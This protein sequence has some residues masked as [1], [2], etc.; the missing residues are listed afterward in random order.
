MLDVVHCLGELERRGVVRA[1]TPALSH[2]DAQPFLDAGFVLHENLHLLSRQLDDEPQTG[3]LTLR[4][5]RP[6]HRRAVLAVDA[7]AFEPFWQF[8][9]FSLRE[10]R[11]ATPH[12]RFRVAVLDSS[13]VGYAVT[14]R[15]GA[16]GYLQRLAVSPEAA[17]QGIGTAL[18]QDGF[19]WLRR[20]DAHSVMVNTQ[21]HN[22]RA[23][24]LYEHLG[25]VRQ[26]PGLVVLRWDTTP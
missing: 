15:A 19:C 23:L 17:G 5:G 16:R 12:S 22:H 6:W 21:E 24:G 25:F 2:F 1:I 3:H 18:V 14:G 8:D 26:E 20:R 11:Q 7:Q 9:R 13:V 4:T 10:A